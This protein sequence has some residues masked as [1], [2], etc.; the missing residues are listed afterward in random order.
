MNRPETHPGE[1][2][3]DPA[4]EADLAR[5][6]ARLEA[7]LAKPRRRGRGWSLALGAVG[8]AAIVAFVLSSRRAP[9]VVPV[10]ALPAAPPAIAK[11]LPLLTNGARV[12]SET[13]RTLALADGSRIAL[14]EGGAV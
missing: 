8:T 4:S 12:E 13:T 7:A 11:A 6:W 1:H 5:Q 10:A 3:I 9:F 14:A 2:M